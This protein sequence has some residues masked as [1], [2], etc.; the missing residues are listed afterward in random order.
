M[1]TYRNLGNLGRLGNELF[2]YA[3]T[4]LYAHLNGFSYA[5]PAWEGSE[6]L[7]TDVRPWTP[8]QAITAHL[9]PTILLD[10]VVS[11]TP[12]QRIGTAL[13]L[14]SNSSM[15][16][17]WNRPCDWV[18][19][20]GYMQDAHSLHMLSSHRELVTSWL[21]FRPDFSRAC[22]A[23]VQ[24]GT[25]TAIHIRRGDFVKRG[26]ALEPK[27]Y[28]DRLRSDGVFGPLYIAS[29]DPTIPSRFV[30][31]ETITST[32]PVD[33]PP[34]LFDFWMIANARAVYG[35][36]STFSWWGAFLSRQAPYISPPLTHTWAPGYKPE[37]S[38]Q[39]L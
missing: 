31:F 17:L 37:L 3:G 30:D 34:I 33:I 8:G 36:G 28:I 9:L 35:C 24:T 13:H 22:R 15:K 11:R 6:T 20:Y 18:N 27:V 39:Y 12:L 5:M 2:Q 23:Q 26:L 14:S 38:L 16:E 7:F 10:D 4:R 29:D 32:T 25:W 19:I 1:I 21:Q